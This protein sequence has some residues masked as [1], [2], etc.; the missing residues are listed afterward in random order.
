V[1]LKLDQDRE[2]S[3]D[4]KETYVRIIKEINY[5]MGKVDPFWPQEVEKIVDNLKSIVM[6]L[7]G[8]LIAIG[9]GSSLFCGTSANPKQLENIFRRLAGY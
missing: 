4:K 9:K 7:E 2:I 8:Q 3:K 5:T 6:E 1:E